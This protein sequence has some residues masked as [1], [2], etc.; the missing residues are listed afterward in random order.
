MDC[1]PDISHN[2]QLSVA[3]RII[4]C[5]LTKGV[6]IH[7]HFMGFLV[8]DDSTG[9]GLLDLF[10]GHLERLGL[11]LSNCCGQS[12]DNGSNMQW[13]QQGVQVRLLELNPKAL[14]VPCGSHT[15]NMVVGDVAKS[16]TISFGYF[17]I[18]QRLYNLFSGSVQPAS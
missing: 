18:I 15:L 7:K 3:L 12:Y 6:S 5:E 10:L 17:G 9:K 4:N 14:C 8:A 13:K 11:D 1:P 2:E 16:S